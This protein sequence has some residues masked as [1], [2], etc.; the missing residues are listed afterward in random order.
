[1]FEI[2]QVDHIGIRVRDAARSTA[3]YRKLG[4]EPVYEDDEDP[5][6][7]VRNAQGVELNFVVNA[8]D[9]SG[10]KNVLM[11]VPEKYPGYTHIALRVASMDDTL[12]LLEAEDIAIREGPVELGPTHV[13]VFVRDPDLNVIELTALR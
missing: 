10:D 5:V 6:I 9:E 2:T 4:F 11:D 7:I 3:F 8:G 1:M 12:A 13:S